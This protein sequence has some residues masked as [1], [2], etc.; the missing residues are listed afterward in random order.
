MQAKRGT[1]AEA[2]RRRGRIERDEG[3]YRSRSPFRDKDGER[4]KRII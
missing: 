1:E 2:F 3:E 4:S